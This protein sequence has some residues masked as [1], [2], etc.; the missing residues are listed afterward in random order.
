[1]NLVS[2]FIDD[3]ILCCKC[4]SQI[5][6]EVV[7]EY[8]T[9][10]NQKNRKRIE[11]LVVENTEFDHLHQGPGYQTI[12]T[13][14]T[15]I[16]DEYEELIHKSNYEILKCPS[17]NT[18]VFRM[19]YFVNNI[20]ENMLLHPNFEDWHIL[21]DLNVDKLL[22]D[23]LKGIYREI[24]NSFNISHFLSSSVLVRILLECLCKSEG[25]KEKNLNNMIDQLPLSAEYITALH[26]IRKIGNTA[27]HEAKAFKDELNLAVTALNLCILKIYAPVEETRVMNNIK[28]LSQTMTHLKENRK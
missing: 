4:N 9:Q 28:A 18:V 22:S 3:Y 7:R 26:S 5:Q 19:S 21:P 8:T 24:I 27:A 10:F 2:S 25:I 12:K 23:D 17:C 6:H 20:L 1:M 15:E 13:I 11:I 14:E 16:I